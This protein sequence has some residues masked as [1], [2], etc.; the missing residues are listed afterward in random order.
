MVGTQHLALGADARAELCKVTTADGDAYAAKTSTG[1]QPGLAVADLLA[2]R[3]VG[4][5]PAPVRSLDGGLTS[6]SPDGARLSL[7]RWVA[8]AR[9]LD[10]G[11]RPHEWVRLGELLGR[12]HGVPTD[13][14][15]L[16][17]LP[18]E[19]HDPSAVVE[20]ARAFDDRLGRA[21]AGG[22][23]LVAELATT[24]ALAGPMV[25]EAAARAEQLATAAAWARADL[26]LCHTDPHHGNL[27]VDGDGEVWLVDWDDAMLAPREADLM[28]VVGGVFSH[29]PITEDQVRW[30]FDGYQAST[31]VG[32]GDL[33][34]DLLAYL[35]CV[36][37]LVDVLDFAGT[38]VDVQRRAPEERRSALAIAHAAVVPGALLDLATR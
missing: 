12:L 8:G 36:R 22:D 27:L 4:G 28:F 21:L 25:L 35:R 33:D 37:A 32:V 30:F 38:V 26:V 2:R 13:D 17:G 6:A 34:P 14:P 9:V 7:V 1:D 3:G 19:E 29:A 11:L 23:P 15:V 20:Q 5:V 10:V 24:W 31:G 16:D 18:A